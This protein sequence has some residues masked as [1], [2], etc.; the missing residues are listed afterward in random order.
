MGCAGLLLTVG[1]RALFALVLTHVTAGNVTVADNDV[2]FS[3]CTVFNSSFDRIIEIDGAKMFL[4]H[5]TYFVG[6]F[7]MTLPSS[8]ICTWVSPIRLTSGLMMANSVITLLLPTVIVFNVPFLFFL[9]FIQGVAEAGQQP[10]II[11]LISA[12]STKHDKAFLSSIFITGV[13]TAP[14]LSFVLT[15]TCLCYVSW[16]SIFYIY[17]SL[18]LVWSAVW[19]SQ[20][21]DIPQQHPRLPADQRL[22]HSTHG[23]AVRNSSVAVLKGI[24]WRPIL[25][26]P[27]VW[28][29]FLGSLGRNLIFSAMVVEQPQY[30]LDAFNMNTADIGLLATVPHIGLSVTCLL[31]GII[32]DRLLR[33]GVPITWTR[34]LAFTTGTLIEGLCLVGLFFTREWTTAFLLLS[35]GV[36]IGGVATAGYI[37]L[38]VDIA[39]QYAGVITGLS[40]LGS[41]GAI[42][43]TVL[44]STMTGTAKTIESWQRLFLI[45]GCIHLAIMIV[46]DVFADARRQP[47]AKGTCTTPPITN[48]VSKS[49]AQSGKSRCVGRLRGYCRPDTVTRRISVESEETALL[50]ESLGAGDVDA[51]TDSV[52]VCYGATGSAHTN[53]VPTTSPP[54][55]HPG[56]HLS[57][58]GQ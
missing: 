58:L 33:C 2:I 43:S 22:Y 52:R 17:G 24:P 49:N 44:A 4:L 21:Y 53:S 9:R 31:G 41:A 18:G 36:S 46:F 1:T 37:P 19:L 14:A 39:P 40:Q 25:K 6:Y 30:F 11:G 26:S 47:W 15:S 45:A 13:Y 51:F 20:F 42:I 5:T 57:L 56:Q 34:K 27:T 54:P 12:W 50:T 8:V 48:G 10:I 23:D 29:I 3:D 28:S 55:S 35:L 16:N 32:S 38:A 7:T